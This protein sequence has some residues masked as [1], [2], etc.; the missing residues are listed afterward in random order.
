[1]A[2]DKVKYG[3]KNAHYA[4]KTDT[5]GNTPAYAAP[6]PIPGSVSL[7]LEASGDTTP[8]FA[9]NR[10]YFVTVKNNGYTGDFET[11]L[12][13]DK[14]LQDIFGYEISTTDKVM[15]EN[16]NSQPKEFALLFEEEGD[17]TGTK[18]VL[19]NC[20]C[21][22]PS[23]NLATTTETTEPQT[24]TTSITASPLADGRTMSY[25]TGDTPTAVLESWYEQV[26]LADITAGG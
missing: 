10:Q 7:T 23:R 25:T 5:E 14:F 4:V 21:T 22:R 20:T 15:T 17:M 1:M 8:F 2:A 12:F 18:Y 3:I 9:D 13:P 24:Q 19:Y 16:A 11:A 26:W 6:V